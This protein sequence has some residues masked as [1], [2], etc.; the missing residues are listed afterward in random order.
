MQQRLVPIENQQRRGRGRETL[1]HHETE[2]RD[3]QVFLQSQGYMLRPRLRPGWTPS[4]IRTGVDVL[5]AEDGA[6]TPIR[7]D[8]VDATRISDGRLVYL[9]RV[10]TE[11]TE[12]RIAKFLSSEDLRRDPRNHSVPILDVFT[13]PID[14]SVSYMVMPFLR[15]FNRPPFQ[16]VG[17]ILDLGEQ[18]LEGLVFLH[19]NGVAH[20][21]CAQ[22]NL[23]MDADAMY[24]HGFHPVRD[25]Y[26]PDGVTPAWPK[27]R[28][29]KGVKYY[30][31]DYGISSLIPKD[32][33]NKLVTGT[34]GRDQEVPELSESIPYDPFKVDIFV[35]GNV[36]KEE[37][38]DKYTNVGFLAPFILSMTKRR[39]EDRPNAQQLLCQWQAMRRKFWAIQ[40]HWMVVSCDGR[41][42]DQLF[43]HVASVIRTAVHLIKWLSGGRYLG[44]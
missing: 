22:K 41:L 29:E 17:E 16:F 30:Y 43:W 42:I 14:K 20:R 8:L 10:N 11:D 15:L 24:P 21:D 33:T 36:F 18:L 23:M 44:S 19:E 6:T 35:L 31:V 3:R 4:W 27:S 37:I 38:Y 13:D 12:Y 2:W 7:P 32:S 28:L 25:L 26:L 5:R 34:L 1:R 39:P 40:K 9:K